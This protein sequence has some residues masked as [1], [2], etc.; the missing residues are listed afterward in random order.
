MIKLNVKDQNGKVVGE[1]VLEPAIFEAPAKVDLVHQVAVAMAANARP[2]LA[3]VKNRSDVRGGGRKPWKQKG[4]GRARQGSIRAPQWRGGGSVFGPKSD[5]NFAQKINKKM[6]R[7]ALFGVLSD[8][9]KHEHVSIVDKF[10]L[11]VPKTKSLVTLFK[12]VGLPQSGVL[13][14]IPK[15]NLAIQQSGRN[16]PKIDIRPANSL[17]VVDALNHRQIIFTSES[18]AAFTNLYIKK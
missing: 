13:F 1:T 2:V 10:D 6:K 9:A 8:R 14:I 4:T 5:R 11:D 15:S 7:A 3:N 16:L 18:L 12:N 17:N